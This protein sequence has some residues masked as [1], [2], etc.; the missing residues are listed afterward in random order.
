MKPS[1]LSFQLFIKFL[2]FKDKGDAIILESN[3]FII[4]LSKIEL[5]GSKNK[6]FKK[7]N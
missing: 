3:F 1:W 5:K 2:L 4:F 6:I 7:I